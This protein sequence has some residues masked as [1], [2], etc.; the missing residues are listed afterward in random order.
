MRGVANAELTPELAFRLGEAAGTF[1]ATV[2]AA[3]S[4][5]AAIPARAARCS[6]QRSWRASWPAAQDAPP[7]GI[8]PTPAV[9]LL[10][11]EL[12]ADGGVVISASHNA[13][14]YNGIKLFSRDGFKLPDELEDEIEAFCEDPREEWARPTGTASDASCTSMTRLSAT[15]CTASTPSTWASPD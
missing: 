15:S 8:V 4:S 7:C 12:E 14:E 10:V 9:A 13:P 11:R 2:G 3:A 1:S 5:S 6:R